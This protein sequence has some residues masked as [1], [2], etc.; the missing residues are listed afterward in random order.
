MFPIEKR[1]KIWARVGND[2]LFD[3]SLALRL[4]SHR[5]LVFLDH[6]CL[7]IA[8]V[9][10]SSFLFNYWYTFTYIERGADWRGP[11]SAAGD[12]RVQHWTARANNLWKRETFWRLFLPIVYVSPPIWNVALLHFRNNL[13]IVEGKQLRNDE[14]TFV[15]FRRSRWIKTTAP[16]SGAK[17][18][19]I[20]KFSCNW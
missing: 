20:L 19:R 2:R 12:N 9:T 1:G 7:G 6:C 17:P 18:R 10:A 14:Y 16:Y 8:L 3:C 4:K 13:A 5:P 15:G 11:A